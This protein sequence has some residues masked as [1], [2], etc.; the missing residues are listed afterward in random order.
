MTVHVP[1]SAYYTQQIAD[2]L[3]LARA[4][5]ALAGIGAAL[6]LVSLVPG[7]PWPTLALFG[8]AHMGLGLV[9]TFLL[10]V[11]VRR[12]RRRLAHQFKLHAA[13]LDG[14]GTSAHD[15]A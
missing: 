13:A 10:L 12:D 3:S 1:H 6:G 8:W 5:M 14:T 15:S 2:S 9:L 7:W 4:S 11:M